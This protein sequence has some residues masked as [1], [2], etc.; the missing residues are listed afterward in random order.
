MDPRLLFPSGWGV[1]IMLRE[2]KMSLGVINRKTGFRWSESHLNIQILRVE[3]FWFLENYKWIHSVYFVLNVRDSF[4][5]KWKICAGNILYSQVLTFGKSQVKPER[6]SILNEPAGIQ[7]EVFTFLSPMAKY[8]FPQGTQVFRTPEKHCLPG[9]W[10]PVG[11]EGRRLADMGLR[12]PV[13]W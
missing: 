1:L 8:Q 10:F 13:R 3:V 4:G 12:L 9:L 6:P 5:S 11:A 2:G 7:T